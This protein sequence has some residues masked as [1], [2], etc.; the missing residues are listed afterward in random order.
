GLGL[1][2]L[3]AALNVAGGLLIGPV[4][5]AFA[6]FKRLPVRYILAMAALSLA[7][8][9]A[10]LTGYHAS[11]PKHPPFAALGHVKDLFVYVLTYFGASWTR[12]LP[13]KE[14]V[15]CLVSFVCFALLT[16]RAVRDR[17][18]T[19]NFE[20]FCI[21]ECVFTIAIACL[22]ALGRLQF[23]VGQAYAGRYQTPAM[24]YWSSLC[25]LALVNFWRYRPIKFR[26]LQAAVLAV[27]LL[28][29]ATYPWMWAS[30]VKR[31]DMLRSACY[32]VMHGDKDER[33]A[34]LL[35]PIPQHMSQAIE[36]L[37]RLW[38]Q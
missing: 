15:T 36:Y 25:A 17:G 7:S 2:L 38:R 26:Y 21:A 34:K 22:T 5:I 24:L 28:S 27:L 12:L 16:V 31:G 8:T 32:L 23:G 1:A 19:S 4:S 33:T 9:A 11:D 20:W 30:L 3:F 13:H 35:F 18:R 37:H 10:Y 29:T 6:I 14:R